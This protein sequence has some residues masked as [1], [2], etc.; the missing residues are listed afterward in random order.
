MRATSPILV[1][2]SLGLALMAPADASARPPH[3]D[4]AQLSW[5]GAEPPF[6]AR[7]RRDDDAPVPNGRGLLDLAS[8]PSEP[9]GPEEIT[10][11]A[12]TDALR[13]LCGSW[14]P[15][16]RPGLYAGWIL[17]YSAHF[18][19]DPLLVAG[20]VISR[21]S[22]RPKHKSPEGEGLSQIHDKMHWGSLRK[23]VYR[24]H[25]FTE[26]GWDARELD[27]G[28][29]QF[30][31][32]MLRA[33]GAN[34]Y[35]TAA[36][37]RVATEQCPHNDGAFGSVAHRHPVSHV[38]WGDRVKG[39]DGEDQ[40]LRIRRMLIEQ[41]TGTRADLH[42]AFGELRIVS[43]LDGAPRKITSA[44]GDERDGGKRK[45]EGIDFASYIG[46]PVR[47]M[48]DGVVIFSGIGGMNIGPAG[49]FAV[50]GKP[51]GKA[52][53][54]VKIQHTG[55]V[56]SAYMHLNDTK[57]ARGQ[58]V[59]AGQVIGHVGRT[60][61]QKSSAHLHFEIRHEG[62]RVDPMPAMGNMVFGPDVTWRGL[63]IEYGRQKKL[64][65]ARQK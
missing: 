59:K 36:F 18:Q 52:G 16:A 2:L 54:Y 26:S 9:E 46:E 6:R 47:A 15:K 43:P 41:L 60:G 1:T 11:E 51:L 29:F 13:E 39:T 14:Q 48:A 56:V 28:R 27:V 23:G 12:L 7:M 24:Y 3:L 5:Q 22:C 17:E 57:V 61:I 62:V 37:L 49:R 10:H 40:V 4:R 63:R 25:V 20:L 45:H 44:M 55:E 65:E 34:I 21:S 33:A 32:Y 8:W 53:I 30:S 38:I 42:G 19:V 35:F 31:R 50:A 64:R 58:E